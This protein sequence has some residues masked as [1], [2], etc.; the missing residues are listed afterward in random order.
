MLFRS[1]A[2]DPE[3]AAVSWSLREPPVG[4]TI[5]GATGKIEW[6]STA[7]GQQLVT[8]IATDPLGARAIQSYLL[9][10]AR[11]EAPQITS[12][13]PTTAV[14]GGLYRYDVSAQDPEGDPLQYTLIAPPSGMTIDSVGRLRWNVPST[15]LTPVNVL[16]EVADEIGRAHV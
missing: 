13:P 1:A 5:D 2:R 16:V 8:V 10:T 9:S 3:G 4:M 11:N 12:T 7:A 15:A 14:A 6:I